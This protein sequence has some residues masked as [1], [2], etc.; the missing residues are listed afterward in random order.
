MHD[1]RRYVIFTVIL[2]ILMLAKF[3]FTGESFAQTARFRGAN[4]RRADWNPVIA[5]DANGTFLSVSIDGRSFSNLDDGVYMDDDLKIMIP[6][7]ML[8]D[9]F[10]CSAHVYEKEQLVVE[11]KNKVLQ[12]QPN[13]NYYIRNEE[14]KE[15]DGAAA[16]KEEGSG[17]MYVPLEIL[18]QEFEYSCQWDFF[19]SRYFFPLF[20]I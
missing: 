12:F 19:S 16:K 15:W 11:K 6:E 14:K 5:A 13:Q 17:R 18:A 9:A 2:C 1:A 10:D 8:R 3:Q 7:T 4:L 20:V